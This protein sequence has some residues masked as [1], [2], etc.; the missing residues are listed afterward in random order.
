MSDGSRALSIALKFSNS[1]PQ[2]ANYY[3]KTEA[4]CIDLTPWPS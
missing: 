3:G 4:H 1:N 2:F